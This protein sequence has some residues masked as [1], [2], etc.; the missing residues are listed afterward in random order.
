MLNRGNS[1]YYSSSKSR[2][3]NHGLS[4]LLLSQCLQHKTAEGFAAASVFYLLGVNSSSLSS[5]EVIFSCYQAPHISQSHKKTKGTSLMVEWW[6]IC[7]PMPG[8]QVQSWSWKILHAM[9]Q[10]TPLC[11]NYW[12]RSPRGLAPQMGS[13]HREKP[14]HN[15]EKS[16][17][18]ATREK[19]L[20]RNEHRGQSKIVLFCF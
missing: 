6:R 13:H 5:N 18:T 17:L 7:L 14:N 20:H 3:Y 12:A 8:S 11:H 2:Y 15:E 10:L 4:T 19:P 9:G 16:L 1:F